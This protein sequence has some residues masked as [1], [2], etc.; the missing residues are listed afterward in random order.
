VTLVPAEPE[1]HVRAAR[2]N[3][4]RKAHFDALAA[5]G[6]H[7]NFTLTGI[8]SPNTAGTR[9]NIYV[10]GKLMLVDD[11]WATIGSC[12]LHAYS[13]QGHSELNASF[14]DP[15]LVRALRSELL[16]EHL[17]LDSSGID[18]TAALALYRR[19]AQENRR[20]RDVGNGDWQGLAFA[21]DAATYGE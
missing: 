6:R 9:E 2:R 8:A 13:L 20:K 16:V 17:G 7:H 19:I 12:N 5:L 15:S 14:W 10:H 21:L 18:S 3:P 11:A 4:D 1:E